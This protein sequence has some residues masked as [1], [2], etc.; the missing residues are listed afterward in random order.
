M[1]ESKLPKFDYNL[2]K[3]DPDTAVLRPSPSR[4]G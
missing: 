3:E 1:E 2:N 4:G